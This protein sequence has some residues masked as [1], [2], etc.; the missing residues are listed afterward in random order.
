[1]GLGL[2]LALLGLIALAVPIWLHR[3]RR[4]LL[5]EQPL[6]TLRLLQRAVAKK[7]RTV[8][9]RDRALLIA[10]MCILALAALALAQPFLSRV[11]SYATERPIALAIVIDDSMST[12]RK[13]NQIST[14]FDRE[15]SRARSVLDELA[16]DSEAA[17]ILGGHTP[18]VL[19]A[20]TNDLRTS[21][22][23]LR[24]IESPSA[25][26]TALPDAVT[27]AMRELASTKLSVREVLVLTDCA[28]HAKPQ[29]LTG[30]SSVRVECI[31][32]R[33]GQENVYVE[34]VRRAA[35]ADRD[36]QVAISVRVAG[37]WSAGP[38]DVQLAIDGRPASE[39]KVTLEEG[40][41]TADLKLAERMLTDAHIL[42]VSL[43]VRD[44]IEADDQREISLEQAA[45]LS[46]LLVDGDPA[47]SQRDDELRFL[48]LAL[49]LNEPGEPTPRVTRIDADGLGGADL[50]GYDV[51][52]LANVLAPSEA[53]SQQ[54]L[55]RVARG[56]GLLITAGD[57]VDPFAYR[58]RFGAL[59]PALIR[60]AAQAQPSLSIDPALSAVPSLVPEGGVGLETGRTLE[61]LLVEAVV[62]PSETALAFN[63]GTPLLIV[64][65]HERG[66][67]ALF[68]TT[69][70][71]DWTD[72][73]LTPGFLPLIHGVVRGLSALDALPPGPHLAGTALTA[74]IPQ[75]AQSIFSVTPDG[76]R[77][78]LDE[79]STTARITDTAAPGVYRT[80]SAFDGRGERELPQLSFEVI[81]DI[82]DS[83]L[84]IAVMPRAK[85]STENGSVGRPKSVAPWMWLLLGIAA[86]VEG[87]MRV[88]KRRSQVAAAQSSQP[89]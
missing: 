44:A 64:G 23:A 3:V 71:D 81:P 12:S 34:S 19:S 56:A 20:R 80:F 53:V 31:A 72:L 84:T 30:Q 42:R 9:F 55:A 15:V 14:V 13:A 17:I 4:K 21:L 38:F 79:K 49:D 51:I 11:A 45:E 87:A 39:A 27:L 43:G 77:I 74:R 37:K 35:A 66:R 26:G 63:D 78:E 83:D 47:P 16:P 62:L 58:G 25:R 82:A 70:D 46:V 76:R 73:P 7:R 61:R 32:P 2:P 69:I 40:H 24:A 52:V 57:H 18:R 68:T 67:I 50:E 33:G 89:A 54:L 28:E 10:R 48:S 8:R 60:S 41:G 6:P 75:G 22:E 85:V 59:M 5:R 88:L 29:T 86:I 36:G 65:R 1:V